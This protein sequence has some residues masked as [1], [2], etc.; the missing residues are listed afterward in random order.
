MLPAGARVLPALLLPMLPE[1]VRVLPT[2]LQPI[3][4][5]GRPGA[6]VLLLLPAWP[7]PLALLA[8]QQRHWRLLVPAGRMQ[9]TAVAAGAKV[10][11]AAA[12]VC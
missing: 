9:E 10:A 7:P 8:L 3:L 4:P 5:E 2:F 1:D 11:A 12:A 6:R